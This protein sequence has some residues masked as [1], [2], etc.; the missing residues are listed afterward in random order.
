MPDENADLQ[1]ETEAKHNSVD[2]AKPDS[3]ASRPP[4]TGEETATGVTQ[5]TVESK[6]AVAANQVADSSLATK[7]R[8]SF[9]QFV[10]VLVLLLARRW[11][12]QITSM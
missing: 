8:L 2:A 10:P 5:T 6:G 4:Q 3:E 12:L 1:K 7:R 11:R 9:Q